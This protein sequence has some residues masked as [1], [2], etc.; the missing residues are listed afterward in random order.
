MKTIIAGYPLYNE[1]Y[2][3][4]C[5][6]SLGIINFLRKQNLVEGS[7][8]MRTFEVPGYGG[9]LIANRTQEQ[10]EFFEEDKEAV[11]FGNLQE[12]EDKL[13]FLSARK[14]LVE[15]LKS[16]ALLRARKSNYSYSHRTKQLSDIL[17]S[18]I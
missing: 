16:Q 11:Y 12:L 5:K 14:S 1:Q 15:T 13:T 4:A 3:H 7:H 18:T 6:N 10:L 8:N 2:A 17:K 9:L